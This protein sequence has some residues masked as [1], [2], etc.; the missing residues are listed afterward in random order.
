M[1]V[2]QWHL[3]SFCFTLGYLVSLSLSPEQ[4]KVWVPSLGGGL[5]SN[6]TLVGYS[7]KLYA[8]IA[9]AYP[10]GWTPL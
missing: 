10:V 7:H 1:G 3:E 6:Q 8:S 9:L 2:V 5:K 4:C